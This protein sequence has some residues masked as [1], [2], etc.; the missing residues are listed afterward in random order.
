MPWILGL[1]N[2]KTT[3]SKKK[4]TG[5][6]TIV[7]KWVLEERER[8]DRENENLIVKVG[9]NVWPLKGWKGRGEV[10]VIII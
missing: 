4:G 8:E 7:L 2:K 10:L 9:V 6:V 3:E 1:I 5:L